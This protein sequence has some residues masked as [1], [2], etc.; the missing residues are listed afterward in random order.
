[1]TATGEYLSDKEL[2]DALQLISKER[3]IELHI[4]TIKE[5]RKLISRQHKPPLT[6]ETGPA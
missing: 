6:G 2:R 5:V 3:L 1:M 4:T